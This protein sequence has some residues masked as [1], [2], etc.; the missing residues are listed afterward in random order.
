MAGVERKRR[1][2]LYSLPEF[3]RGKFRQNNLPLRASKKHN[4]YINQTGYKHIP[5]RAAAV[6]LRRIHLPEADH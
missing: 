5:C 3:L 6:R 1:R 4:Y 2:D